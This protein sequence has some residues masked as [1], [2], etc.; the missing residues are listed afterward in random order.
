MSA[1]VVGIFLALFTRHH[2]RAISASYQRRIAEITQRSR[3]SLQSQQWFKTT[4]ESIGDAVIACTERGAVT[5]MNEVAEKLTGW[6]LAEAKGKPLTKVFRIVNEQTRQPAEN[7]VE[8]VRR[9]KQVVGLA[10][11]TVLIARDSREHV[12]DDSAAPIMSGTEKMVGVVLVF[13]DVTEER[14]VQAALAASEKL[15]VAGR[16][17]ASIAHEIHNPLDSV[18]NLHYLLAEE[19]DPEKREEFLR[20]AQAGTGP[21]DADQPHHAEPVSRAESANSDQSARAHRGVLLLLDRRLQHQGIHLE[22]RIDGDLTVEGFPAELQQVFTNLIVNTDFE[23]AGA[24]GKV[25]AYTLRPRTR[26]A[27]RSW[28]T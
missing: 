8:K 20:L 1:A 26:R 7:P 23:A 21:D 6:R 24:K 27:A 16:L 22:T 25:S 13:R 12:I 10:N 18:A 28:G 11:H 9:M 2:V 17:A 4:L 3:R 15:A 14:Q 19:S 5:F